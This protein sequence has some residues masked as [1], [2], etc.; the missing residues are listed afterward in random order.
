MRPAKLASYLLSVLALATVLASPAAAQDKID[1]PDITVGIKGLACP[2]C[3]YGLEL[4]LKKLKGVKALK[5]HLDD[6]MVTIKLEKGV[7][8]AEQQIRDAVL[9][10]GF[11]VTDIRYAGKEKTDAKETDTTGRRR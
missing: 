3:A 6:S 4:R 7:D 10:A 8:L 2:F 11:T 5:V 9:D 1:Y